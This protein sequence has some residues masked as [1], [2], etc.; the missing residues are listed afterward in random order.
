MFLPENEDEPY[1]VITHQP[2][3]FNSCVPYFYEC[4]EWTLETVFRDGGPAIWRNKLCG[5]HA[6]SDHS[7]DYMIGAEY[8]VAHPGRNKDGPIWVR[9]D[10]SIFIVARDYEHP[11]L[12][13]SAHAEMPVEQ[14]EKLK[15]MCVS[16]VHALQVADSLGMKLKIGDKTSGMFVSNG[17]QELR[18]MAKLL[19]DETVEEG[20]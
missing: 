10:R 14:G 11:N 17:A 19:E 8:Y 20:T 12:D 9:T 6:I 5:K 18:V 13:T 4:K 15:W 16:I 1:P 3:D 2:V 7:A